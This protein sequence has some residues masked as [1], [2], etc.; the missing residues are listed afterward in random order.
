[1]EDNTKLIKA[2]LAGL[3]AGVAIGILIAPEKG[4]D[5]QDV[6]TGSFKNLGKSIKETAANEI[7]HLVHLKDEIVNAVKSTL[8]KNEK[9]LFP[10][11]LEHA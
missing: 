11:D 10:D 8:I 2:L 7:N 6:L 3:A 5:T 1:M 4:K 9:A